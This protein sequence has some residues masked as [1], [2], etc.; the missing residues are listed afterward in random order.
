M[1]C[2]LLDLPVLGAHPSPEQLMQQLSLFYSED[3]YP[4]DVD[5]QGFAAPQT[6]LLVA[7]QYNLANPALSSEVP[8]TAAVP[9]SEVLPV[10]TMPAASATRI[11][12]HE[13]VKT[14]FAEMGRKQ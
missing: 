5:S 10:E 7:A 13:F 11:N 14:C 2:Q 9:A 1:G 4:E 12:A 8:E 3:L 6:D